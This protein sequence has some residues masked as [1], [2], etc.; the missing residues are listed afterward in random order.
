MEKNFPEMRFLKH[1]L[2]NKG[3]IA[4]FENSLFTKNTFNPCGSE[5]EGNTSETETETEHELDSSGVDPDHVFHHQAE[6][7]SYRT[8]LHIKTVL[9]EQSFGL[10]E[11]WPSNSSDL[12]D[13]SQHS[14]PVELFNLVAYMTSLAN[15]PKSDGYADITTILCQETYVSMSGHSIPCLSRKTPHTKACC[16]GNDSSTLDRICKTDT[17]IE[18]PGSH[19]FQLICN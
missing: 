11:S 3:D 6:A 13:C 4:Y 19:C 18:W 15:E 2:Q 5:E 1:N 12:A 14:F 7:E 10:S 16:I 8:G 17:A 9:Q